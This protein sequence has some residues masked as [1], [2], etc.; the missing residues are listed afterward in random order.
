MIANELLNRRKFSSNVPKEPNKMKKD[1]PKYS[2]DEK[3]KDLFFDFLKKHVSPK[4]TN[5][6]TRCENIDECLFEL[7]K[8]LSMREPR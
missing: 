3:D 6:I 8:P 7:I 5:L 1:L 2:K 4:L